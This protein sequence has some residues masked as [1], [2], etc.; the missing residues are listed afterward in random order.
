MGDVMDSKGRVSLSV[1]WITLFLMGT[2]LFVVSTLLPFI[3]VAYNVSSAMTGWMV[4]RKGNKE[5]YVYFSEQALLDL[6][7]YLGEIASKY[8]VLKITRRCLL[9]L[10]WALKE[11]PEGYQPEQS[12][13]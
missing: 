6:E 4:I 5:Q 11:Q 13:K 10:L 2:D 1:G 7:A 3:S 8:N 12:R 9:Q